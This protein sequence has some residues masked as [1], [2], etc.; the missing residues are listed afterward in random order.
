MSEESILASKM[1]NMREKS[2]TERWKLIADQ[3]IRENPVQTLIWLNWKLK[4][5][6]MLSWM[7]QNFKYMK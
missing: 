2:F 5:F 1:K 4:Y 7:A 6:K 3:D